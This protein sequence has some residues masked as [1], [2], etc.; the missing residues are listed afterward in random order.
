[1]A[2]EDLSGNHCFNYRQPL[3]YGRGSESCQFWPPR[4]VMA[5]A[6][7]QCRRPVRKLLQQSATARRSSIFDACD[8]SS[9]APAL[10]LIQ[11]SM[12][13]EKPRLRRTA[14]ATRRMPALFPDLLPGLPLTGARTRRTLGKSCSIMDPVLSV[15]PSSMAMISRMLSRCVNTLSS[16]ARIP[17]E[18]LKHGTMVEIVGIIVIT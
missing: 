9:R 12:G 10:R 16:V 5:Q 2:A 14:A 1:M 6:R 18:A 8:I 4:T 17:F 15:E 7:D 13:K 11:G 3:P